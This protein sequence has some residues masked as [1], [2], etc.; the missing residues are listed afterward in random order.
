MT[1]AEYQR[2]LAVARAL[3]AHWM[4]TVIE[5]NDVDVLVTGMSYSGNAGAAG[6]PALTIPAGL[7]P[8]GRPQGIVLSGP[9]LSEPKLF[10]VGY[11]LEQALKGRVEPNL[12]AT[13]K[14]IQSVTGEQ[15]EDQKGYQE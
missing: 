10:A 5:Q 7:D 4:E 15:I 1:D 8:K 9:Y 14:Q 12:E 6:I 3:A 11:A 2:V 13:I